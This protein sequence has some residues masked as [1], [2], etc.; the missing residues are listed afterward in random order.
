MR[1]FDYLRRTPVSFTVVD[2]ASVQQVATRLRARV[3]SRFWPFHFNR[4][5]GRVGDETL[6]IEWTPGFFAFRTNM[7]PRLS[8][9]LVS[10][11]A[12]V[13]FD[14]RFGAPVFVPILLVLFGC[15][16]AIFALAVI[17]SAAGAPFVLAFLLLWASAPHAMALVAARSADERRQRLVD[18]VVAVGSDR[19][20]L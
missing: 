16:A 6:S 18:F 2:R 19:E 10:T 7:E 9:R 1:Y 13:R 15:I 5:I 14:G 4:V 20:V 12:G 11:N 8:G 17:R 3:G